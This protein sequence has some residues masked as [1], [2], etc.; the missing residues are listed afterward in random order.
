MAE[1]CEGC[2]SL[3]VDILTGSTHANNRWHTIASRHATLS[4]TTHLNGTFDTLRQSAANSCVVCGLIFDKIQ[5]FGNFYSK[6]GYHIFVWGK[7]PKCQFQIAVGDIEAFTKH[8]GARQLPPSV[9][10]F[11]QL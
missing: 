3:I 9:S 11:A 10:L 7:V 1:I 4:Y 8:V 6:F 5:C 2:R